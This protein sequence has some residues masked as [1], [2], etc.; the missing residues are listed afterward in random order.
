MSLTLVVPA[1]NEELCID[2]L[3]KLVSEFTEN[4]KE[5]VALLIIENGSKDSTK[6]KIFSASLRYQNFETIVLELKINE[7]YGGAIKKGIAFSNSDTLMIL[8]ADG[9][10]SLEALE[11]AYE[12][13]KTLGQPNTMVKGLRVLRNDPK[14]VQLLSFL[15][16]VLNNALF[17]VSLKDINGLPKIFNRQLIQKNIG[18][19]P[20]DACFDAGLVVLWKRNGGSFHEVPAVFTQQSLSSTSWSGRKWRVSLRMFTGIMRIF[21]QGLRSD[22]T[23]NV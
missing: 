23:N 10:Y 2:L 20:K 16:T 21:F 15:F 9:K 3:F 6:D 7:G 19:L 18:S 4:R 8:P 13:Y 5:K 12:K 17:H 22:T 14:S 1:Y 11:A